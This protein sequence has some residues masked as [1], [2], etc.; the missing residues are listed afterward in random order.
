M[1]HIVGFNIVSMYLNVI[2][3]FNLFYKSLYVNYLRILHYDFTIHS[4]TIEID[5][6]IK[7][8]LLSHISNEKLYC[9]QI[10]NNIVIKLVLG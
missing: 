8:M 2:T 1:K 3:Y 5:F 7:F 4:N 6:T 9:S 10:M